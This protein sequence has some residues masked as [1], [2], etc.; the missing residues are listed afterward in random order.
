MKSFIR[1]VTAKVI[2]FANF[3]DSLL[4]LPSIPVQSF[5]QLFLP[6]I[7][8]HR[9]YI[10]LPEKITGCIV[11][12]SDGH[13]DISRTPGREVAVV[14]HVVHGE[15]VALVGELPGGDVAGI[16]G[17]VADGET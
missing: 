16:S 6:C 9:Q 11:P 2:S 1:N 17:A 15:A 10:S 3:S 12:P 7:P 5:T 8:N 4:P 13:V 14:P